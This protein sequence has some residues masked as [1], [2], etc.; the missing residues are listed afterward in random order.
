MLSRRTWAGLN[1]ALG[2]WLVSCGRKRPAETTD[3]DGGAPQDTP[4][5]P[6]QLGEIAAHLDGA[7]VPV[8]AFADVVR[9]ALLHGRPF[10]QVGVE[11]LDVET[12]GAVSF[13]APVERAARSDASA[14]GEPVTV[15]VLVRLRA[16][17]TVSGAFADGVVEAHVVWPLRDGETPTEGLVAASDRAAAAIRARLRLAYGE[18]GVVRELLGASDI[19]LIVIGLEWIRRTRDATHIDRV[20]TLIGHVDANVSATAVEIVG[21]IGDVRH[22]PL[23]IQHVRLA[24]PG[25]THRT[26]EALARVGGDQ[27]EGF[28]RFAARNEDEPERQAAARLALDKLMRSTDPAKTRSRSLRGHRQ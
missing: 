2:C 14:L 10:A 21:E 16:P 26:Y 20:A 15:E 13:A 25:H 28:L 9:R 22:A 24:D 19:Q 4:L 7:D 6:Y 12:W 18:P 1:L 23:L 17:E 8:E 3:S 5:G 27:A 11:T